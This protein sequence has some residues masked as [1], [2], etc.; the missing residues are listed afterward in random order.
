MADIG[1]I[2]IKGG[3]SASV[4][5]ETSSTVSAVVSPQAAYAVNVSTP[6]GTSVEVSLDSP[7]FEISANPGVITSV[8]EKFNEIE[9]SAAIPAVG[10]LRLRDLQD[11]KGDPESGQVLVYNQGE[12]NFQFQDQQEGSAG[13][14][15]LLDSAIEVTNTDGAFSSIKGSTFETGTSITTVLSRILD[16][17]ALPKFTTFSLNYSVDGQSRNQAGGT[18]TSHEVGADITMNNYTY[19]IDTPS[20]VKD[21][22]VIL[23]RNGAAFLSGLSEDSTGPNNFSGVTHSSNT[24]TTITYKMSMTEDGNPTGTETT[25]S[26]ST[27]TINFYYKMGVSVGSTIP[28]NNGH[29]TTLYASLQ[30][31]KIIPDPGSSFTDLECSA[32]SANEDNFTFLLIPEAFG[33]LKQVLQENT[34]DVTA[35]FVQVTDSTFTLATVTNINVAYYIYRTI[36]PG[37]FNDGITLKVK[38][39]S[40]A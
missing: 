36:D 7:S 20:N 1:T 8:S 22:S 26:S 25:V 21:D 9:V 28:S 23:N 10:I 3:E 37:V 27:A 13:G 19:V 14:D 5:V 39:N 11:I 24:P 2:E 17:Y 32:L 30:D 34:T 35:D 12:N 33:T 15:D 16:P 40:D 29:A 18:T 38:L 31:S 6:S 4:S